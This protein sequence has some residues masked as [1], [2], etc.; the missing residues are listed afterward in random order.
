MDVHTKEQRSY[1]MSRIRSI[2][3][4][5]ELFLFGMLKKSGLKFK[6]HYP[7]AGKP[8]A[9]FLK[10][11]I[12]VFVDGEYWHGR[13]FNRWKNKLSPFWL[14]KI[15][16]NIKRDRAAGKTLRSKGWRVLRI[17]GKDLI[18]RPDKHFLKILSLIFDVQKK[19]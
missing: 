6:K 2:N 9:V 3:T 13:G 15:S 7:I 5:P 10:E 14:D 18:K 12:A 19:N 4:K 1:N 8:D 16:Q 17:W 11:K